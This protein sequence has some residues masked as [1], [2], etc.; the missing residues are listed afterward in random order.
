MY[1]N[2][3]RSV[4]FKNTKAIGTFD[5]SDHDDMFIIQIPSD[6][7]DFLGPINIIGK[8]KVEIENE[9]KEFWSM[10]NFEDTMADLAF[11][12]QRYNLGY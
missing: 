7:F 6:H 1:S 4:Y 11:E 3:P 8:T 2:Y 9:V 10:Y 5:H 12:A